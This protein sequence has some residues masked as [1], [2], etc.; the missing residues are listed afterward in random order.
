M[1]AAG[2][3]AE[4]ALDPEAFDWAGLA[5]AAGRLFK[6][7]PGL[8][9]MLGPMDAAPKVLGDPSPPCRPRPPKLTR[10]NPTP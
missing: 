2:G 10:Q 5:R 4:G 1:S 6:R 7:A 3:Q 9:C 8:S